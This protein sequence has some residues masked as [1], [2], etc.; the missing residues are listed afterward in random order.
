MFSLNPCPSRLSCVM[1]LL[2]MTA[3]ST[4]TA[5]D[6]IPS[7][8]TTLP[9]VTSGPDSS[10]Q[11][12]PDGGDQDED[13]G[14]ESKTTPHQ[15]TSQTTVEKETP[16]NDA[17]LPVADRGDAVLAPVVEEGAP[18]ETGSPA[19]GS[20]NPPQL[21][22]RASLELAPD[23]REQLGLLQAANQ[24]FEQDSFE[25]GFQALELLSRTGPFSN[26]RLTGVVALADTYLQRG[27]IAAAIKILEAARSQA[28]AAAELVFVL[29]RAYKL[30]GKLEDALAAY[31]DVLLHQPLLLRAHVE[32]GGL[33]G[34]LGK[35]TLA[36]ETMLGYERKIIHFVNLLEGRATH[37]ADKFK[38][39]EAFSLLSDDQVLNSLIV[40][41]K[42]R[43][44]VIRLAAAEALGDVGTREV[45]PTLRSYLSRV[46]S[47]DDAQLVAMLRQSIRRLES[48]PSLGELE[49]GGSVG[50]TTVNPGDPS[51][52]PYDPRGEDQEK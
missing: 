48:Q 34:A 12:S 42:D 15:A 13:V 43:H 44:Q 30:A 22:P 10:M 1:L 21:A 17:Q 41:L 24:A 27:E 25:A 26:S 20:L 9:G 8:H 36:A 39:I 52:A 16:G 31:Q 32:I 19:G 33:Y 46:E 14:L 5:D 38:I 37:P 50:P 4:D 29:G 35:P 49:A 11:P 18:V 45:L 7:K 2:I 47:G 28:P 3:C 40:S 6:G 23:T 51:S